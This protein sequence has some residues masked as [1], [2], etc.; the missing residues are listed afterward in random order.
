MTAPFCKPFRLR[1]AAHHSPALGWLSP[2]KT[3]CPCFLPHGTMGDIDG[4]PLRCYSTLVEPWFCWASLIHSPTP[5]LLLPKSHIRPGLS[6]CLRNDWIDAEL[7]ALDRCRVACP[8]IETL[9]RL[10]RDRATCL[11]IVVSLGAMLNYAPQ[12]LT[13]QPIVVTLLAHAY[14][15]PPC[16]FSWA[17]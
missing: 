10:S 12:N 16:T 15:D 11:L 9:P 13:S 2:D 6:E 14:L 8:R 17:Y 5:S 7:L 4:R 1:C 3:P